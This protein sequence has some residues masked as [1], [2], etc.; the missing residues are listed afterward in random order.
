MTYSTVFCRVF[1]HNLHQNSSGGSLLPVL[2][3]SF[4]PGDIYRIWI[5]SVGGGSH[6]IKIVFV[7]IRFA[8]S[9]VHGMCRRAVPKGEFNT[10]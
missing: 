2:I 4:A 10:Q 7:W 9:S 1:E 8:I 3:D 5:G 6:L